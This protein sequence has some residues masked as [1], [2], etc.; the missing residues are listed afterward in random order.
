VDKQNPRRVVHALEICI[1]TGKTYTSFRT[2]ERKQ[3]PFRIL[4]IALNRPR[5][6]LYNRINLRVDQMMDSGLLDEARLLYP[7][8]HLN[9]L[10]TVGY[11]EL[12]AHLDGKWELSEAV[13]RMKGNTRRYARKQLTWF[14]NDPDIKWIEL[15]NDT[16]AE[17]I[18]RNLNTPYSI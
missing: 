13:E 5:E 6:E 10:N 7:Q 4:K 12:F 1:M 15:K 9:A 2:N 8:R 3:R 14:K 11:K 17:E 18:I 16:T